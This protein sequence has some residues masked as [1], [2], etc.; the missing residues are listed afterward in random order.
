MSNILFIDTSDSEKIN[1]SVGIGG[2][3]IAKIV[4]QGAKAQ[5]VLPMIEKVLKENHLELKK[6]TEIR[7]NT[8]P[9]S[10]TGLRV[11]MTVGKM[12]GFLLDVPVNGK[13]AG[14][15]IPLHYE[16]DRYSS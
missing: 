2:N 8:G 14:E 10:F 9:G 5:M 6:L 15:D 16:H 7:V 3:K 11:G 13:P 12:L 1:V 4:K